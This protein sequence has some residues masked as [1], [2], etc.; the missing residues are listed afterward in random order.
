MKQIS[1]III[2]N[3]MRD[4]ITPCCTQWDIVH[5]MGLYLYDDFS[6]TIVCMYVCIVCNN[7]SNND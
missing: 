1:M 3:T 7:A 2:I 5:M 6:F 4:K